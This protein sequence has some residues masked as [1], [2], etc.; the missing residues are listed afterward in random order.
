VARSSFARTLSTA[1]FGSSCVGD[2][3][4]FRIL[5]SLS[6]QHV[7]QLSSPPLPLISNLDAGSCVL[8]L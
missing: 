6:F 7:G 5:K 8:G 1:D 2:S 3:V 4:H